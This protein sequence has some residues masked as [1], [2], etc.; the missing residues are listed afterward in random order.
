[1]LVSVYSGS[2]LDLQ[3]S[4]LGSYK[5]GSRSPGLTKYALRDAYQCST[6]A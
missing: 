5:L 6:C 3:W 4:Y 1:M 2:D